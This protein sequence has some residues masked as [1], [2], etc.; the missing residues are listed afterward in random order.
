MKILH[1]L[2]LGL[3]AKRNWA[4]WEKDE[5]VLI[6]GGSVEKGAESTSNKCTLEN[7]PEAEN[8]QWQCKRKETRKG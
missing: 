7:L 3:E 6:P 4:K 2:L 1:L 8:A 5:L